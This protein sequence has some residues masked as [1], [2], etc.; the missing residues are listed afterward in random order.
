MGLL[1]LVSVVAAWAKGNVWALVA[2]FVVRHLSP[3]V[4]AKLEAA[5][6]AVDTKVKAAIAWV[7]SK[8]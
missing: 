8:L 7:K 4:V 3:V 2:G 5:W 1:T 6:V